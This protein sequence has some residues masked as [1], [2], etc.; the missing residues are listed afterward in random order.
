MVYCRALSGEVCVKIDLSTIEGEPVPFA[1]VVQIGADRL[2]PTRVAGPM[3]VRLEGTVRPAGDRYLVSGRTSC[4][5]RL[6][7]V[8]CLQP[9]EW[10]ADSAFDLE[11][12]LAA[13]APIDAEVVLDEADLDV[14]YLE[15]P[16]LDLEAMA[17]EQV[18]L[19]LPMRVLCSDN[20][21][22]LCPTCGAD[23]NTE[24]A[25]RCEPETDPRWS[26]LGDLKGGAPVD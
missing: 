15:T 5:G 21:A 14:V 12:A 16:V 8:R 9:V 25:C 18:L 11:I 7:C 26:A 24:G 10:S 22:G 3:K 19:E 6:A 4:E 17:V 2:D 20:C 13:P 1:D 23:R